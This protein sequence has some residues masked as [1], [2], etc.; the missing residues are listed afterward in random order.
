MISEQRS[1]GGGPPFPVE[2]LSR[3]TRKLGALLESKGASIESEFGFSEAEVLWLQGDIVDAAGMLSNEKGID[4]GTAT[5]ELK[6]KL[7]D[8]PIVTILE[9]RV[10]ALLAHE[11]LNWEE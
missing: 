11:G 3:V 6:K 1:N 7:G 8:V 9:R 5:I 10:D 2:D 4:V